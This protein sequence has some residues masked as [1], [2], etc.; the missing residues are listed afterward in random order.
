MSSTAAPLPRSRL[1]VG[2][3][4]VLVRAPV[5]DLSWSMTLDGSPLVPVSSG[6]LDDPTAVRSGLVVHRIRSEIQC[7]RPGHSSAIDADSSE[8]RE[9]SQRREDAA[10]ISRDQGGIDRHAMRWLP[11]TRVVHQQM[12]QIHP[13][14][15][16][17]TQ[18]WF[19]VCARLCQSVPVS[20]VLR[21]KRQTPSILA[22]TR[23]DGHRRHRQDA[24]TK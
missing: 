12:R 9:I 23:T 2:P 20:T 16:A 11:S 8:A 4:I 14:E 22:K 24:P 15:S 10:A 5:A 3:L 7:S 21:F 13:L 17:K 19:A 1:A 18:K 6:L